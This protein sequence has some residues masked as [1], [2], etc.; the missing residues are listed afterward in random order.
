VA[1]PRPAPTGGRLA[2]AMLWLASAVLWLLPANN[3]AGSVHDV[4]AAA[5]SGAGW[6][7]GALGSR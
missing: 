5:P 7:T 1:G 6:L 4:V 2:W 3:G